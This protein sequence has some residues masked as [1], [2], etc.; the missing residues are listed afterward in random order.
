[1]VHEEADFRHLRFSDGQRT[2]FVKDDRFDL[3][4]MKEKYSEMT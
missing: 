1:M 4:E 3:Q 2:G